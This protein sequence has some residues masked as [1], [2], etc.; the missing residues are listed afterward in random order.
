MPLL[1]FCVS[2]IL[3]ILPGM[4]LEQVCSVENVLRNIG[5]SAVSASKRLIESSF[6][7][8]IKREF[9]RKKYR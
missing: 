7:E 8:Q 2:I 5:F 3:C 1:V 4:P 6:K 9:V